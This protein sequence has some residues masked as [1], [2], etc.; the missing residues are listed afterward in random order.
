MKLQKLL[1][2]IAATILLVSCT[3]K[4]EKQ[5]SEST[6]PNVVIVFTD[7]QGYADL[8]CY[9]AKGFTTPNID[10]MAAEGVRFTDFYVAASVCTPSRAALLTGCYAPRVG[11]TTVFFPD[12]PPKTKDKSNLGLNP[13][14]ETI[15]EL[16]KEHGYATALVG[17]WH[18]GHREPF[19]PQKQGFDLF[20]GLP[21]SNDMRPENKPEYPPLELVENDSVIA[22]V[23]A[24]QSMLTTWYTERAVEFIK[25]NKGKPFFLYLAHSMP[26]IPLFVSQK[27]DGKSES[28]YGDVIQEIDWSVGE[29]LKTLKDEGLDDNTLVIF[30]SDN[31]PWLARKLDGCGSALPLRDGKMSVFEGGTR[32]PCVMRYP[33]K[34][35]AGVVNSNILSATDI[36]PTITH[37]TGARMPKAK[38]DGVNAWDMICDSTSQIQVRDTLYYFMWD[39][40][41]AI[42][43]GKWKL[44]LPHS[45]G[46]VTYNDDGSIASAWG[47]IPMQLF[48]LDED[49]SESNNLLEQ[50]PDVA[51]SLQVSAEKF[52]NKLKQEVRPCGKLE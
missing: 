23:G 34:I 43:V 6:K 15:A 20:Y 2:L 52:H 18:L 10:K 39:Q 21:Y 50:Y 3:C 40:L 11:V 33:G 13:N 31:G 44:I 19:L 48:N 45:G 38:I 47:D 26:H 37:I 46:M 29:V 1:S 36:L 22:D 8:G 17:K 5:S 25:D 12:G 41:Q 42:R 9:G 4:K 35:P 7:D 32:V 30:T 24:D 27:Y 16:L 14:E 28:L 51:K 49:I